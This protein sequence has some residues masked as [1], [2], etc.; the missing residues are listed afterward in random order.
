MFILRGIS[1]I[2]SILGYI[3]A[4]SVGYL[5][6]FPVEIA[7]QPDLNLK[8]LIS[9]NTSTAS[10][11]MSDLTQEKVNDLK[12][13]TGP[14]APIELIRDFMGS[15]DSVTQN[16]G[17]S[18]QLNVQYCDVQQLSKEVLTKINAELTNQKKY[19]EFGQFNDFVK[20]VNDLP[21]AKLSNVEVKIDSTFAR[22]NYCNSPITKSKMYLFTVV[23]SGIQNIRRAMMF[24]INIVESSNAKQW[25]KFVRNLATSGQYFKSQV[26]CNG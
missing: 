14:N 23:D 2:L 22:T 15:I 3:L 10:Y 18:P 6:F 25:Q 4:V 13:K 16:I 12:S 24:Q 1:F 21:F 9:C 19:Y 5:G 7:T 17:S 20:S 11:G 8:S 26:N